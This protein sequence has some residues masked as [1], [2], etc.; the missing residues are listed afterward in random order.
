M[1]S[2]GVDI[3]RLRAVVY[4][5]NRLTL[6][7]FRQIVGRV[8]RTDP[9]NADDHGRVYLPGDARLIEMASQITESAD[10][11]PP[12]ILIFTDTESVQRVAIAGEPRPERVP[13]E[14]L[15]TTAAAGNVFDT[16]GRS[17]TADL[18][19]CARRFIKREGLSDT[20]PAS[21]ALAAAENPELR[22]ALLGLSD[23]P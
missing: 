12:P 8:V 2:E 21:L 13:F 6:L 18:V 17:A 20:D 3:T 5:T 19:D 10:I 14:T 16:E 23:E 15:R 22:A 11:L 7:A 4:L 1:I 9:A